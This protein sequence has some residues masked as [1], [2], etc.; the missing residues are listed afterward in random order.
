MELVAP[1][2]LWW[3]LLALALLWAGAG[4]LVDRPPLLKWSSVALRA[5]AVVL[6]A[7][8]L[9]RPQMLRAG[10]Q[11]HRVHLLDVS[12]SVDP[13]AALTA[14]DR[15][16]ADTAELGAGDSW[17]LFA[18][19]DGLRALEPDELRSELE[20]W[21]A[22]ERAADDYRSQ[23]R[24][25]AGLR[26]ARLDMPA[27]RRREVVLHSDG[28]TTD[29]ELLAA[30]AD[31]EAERIALR[32]EPLAGL[33][34]D[35]VALAGLTASS[36]RAYRGE[37]LR[38]R[39]HVAAN[40]PNAA[41]VRILR[42]GVVVAERTIEI[43]QA[44][45]RTVDFDLTMNA[46]GDLR[47]RCEVLAERDH[48]LVNN[49][50]ECTVTVR[51]QPR[52]LVLHQRDQELRGFA[53]ALR[54]QGFEVELRGRFG[55]PDRLEQ[56]LAFDAIILAELPATLLS[57]RQMT[58]VKRY[59]TDFGGG[60]AMMGSEESFGL[61]GYFQT[62]IEEVLPLTSRY[63]KEK[64]K[65]S[66]AMVL[67]IDKSGSMDGLPIALARQAA[68][69]T[70]DVLSP[71]DSIGVV[72][73]DG[74]AYL[75]SELRSAAEGESV[76]SAIDAIGADGGTNMFPG[77]QVAYDQLQNAAA[78]IKHVIILGDGQ[79]NDGDFLGLTQAMADSGITV[80]TVALGQGADQQLLGAIAQVGGGRGY[81]TMDPSTVPQIFTKETL[82]ASNSAIKEDLYTAVQT[83]DHPL[84][85]GYRAED[86]PFIL[87]YVMTQA[88]PTAQVLLSVETG[89]PLLAVGRYGLGMGLA[90]TADMSERWGAEWLAWS[91]V[92]RFW[93]QALRPILRKAEASGVQVEQVL[94]DGRWVLEIARSDDSGAPVAGVDWRLTAVGDVQGTREIPVAEVGLGRY[95]AEVP[96]DADTRLSLS[97]SDPAGGKQLTLHHQRAYPDEYRLSR[98]DVG[99]LERA[100][101]VEVEAVHRRSPID[102]WLLLA[103]IACAL[104]GILLRRV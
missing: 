89:D 46:P 59:V 6:L 53:R 42:E 55:L 73:F 104:G 50:A 45:T 54:E 76:K 29:P 99:A 79:S 86:L 2:A 77:M 14:L 3:S 67:V 24:L 63:E 62:P 22:G 98:G 70:V 92:G 60:L 34:H 56:M 88:K 4:G 9:T 95:R 20:A 94:E 72:A 26:A 58:L 25:A 48:F 12:H 68:K 30:L 19:A 41:R 52:I 74:S 28:Q 65:P 83:G 93:A 85:A 13:A 102:R 7:L 81:V 23:S 1:E 64:E 84:L 31:L 37:V 36:A 32:F 101:A 100:A 66:L 17:S 78:K 38:L 61:G 97:L 11:L 15:I 27:E 18:L 71:R 91:E 57:D 33:A 51:G 10:D 35:E 44:G 49:H 82:E 87:G 21:T 80:S 40:G 75:V 5:L 69:A 8:A 47:W 96:L 39:A 103:A 16:E 90:F 43:E